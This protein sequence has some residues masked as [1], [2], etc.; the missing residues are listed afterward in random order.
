MKRRPLRKK[1]AAPAPR[2]LTAKRVATYPVTKSPAIPTRTRSTGQWYEWCSQL[3]I[4]DAVARTPL[5]HVT[6][7]CVFLQAVHT[8]STPPAKK[9]RNHTI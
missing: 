2:Y 5:V 6:G 9:H 4:T 8:I 7:R 1:A 3:A